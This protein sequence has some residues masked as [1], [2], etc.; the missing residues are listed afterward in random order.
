[1]E[2]TRNSTI[3][4]PDFY[5]GE[6]RLGQIPVFNW[7]RVDLEVHFHPSAS[8]PRITCER[9]YLRWIRQSRET[10]GKVGV[11]RFPG[12]S[13]DFPAVETLTTGR[14]ERRDHSIDAG[15]PNAAHST[16]FGG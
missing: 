14:V 2:P 10:T 12:V 16:K 4:Y 9:R 6:T 15:D 13:R 11:S 1:M 5:A 3:P 7:K 8:H